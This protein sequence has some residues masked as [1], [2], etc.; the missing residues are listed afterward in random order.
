MNAQS[1][2]KL[3][4]CSVDVD[5]ADATV[6]KAVQ[7]AGQHEE[8]QEKLA[9]QRLFDAFQLKWMAEISVPPVLA[10]RLRGRKAAGGSK[11]GL[12]GLLRQPA[13][14]AVAIAL[15]VMAGWFVYSAWNWM[16]RFQGE[17]A[18]ID[19]LNSQAALA[20]PGKADLK[21]T[22]AGMLGDWLFSKYGFENY[23]TPAELAH[24][25]TVGCRVF[26]LDGFSVA[27]VAVEEHQ[28]LCYVFRSA[29]FGVR[30]APPDQWHVFESDDWAVAI[31]AHDDVCFVMTF[32]GRAGEMRKF[33]ATF[34]K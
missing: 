18:V 14:L 5:A 3:L 11:P 23:Y 12:G 21:T 28:T 19:L 7:Y 29:D 15:L 24:L 8:L 16:G 17:D 20:L 1:A 33:L 26:K 6:R 25:K 32:Q 13:V 2:E 22:E 4:R 10:E 30:I 31:Q 34:K 9:Q 27:Q